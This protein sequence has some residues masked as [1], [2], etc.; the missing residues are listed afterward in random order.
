LAIAISNAWA[1][2]HTSLTVS[3]SPGDA[4]GEVAGV[5]EHGHADPQPG[6]DRHV[7]D[8]LHAAGPQRS[9]PWWR[10][11]PYCPRRDLWPFLAGPKT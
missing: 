5:G 1:R 10:A 2:F 11:P 7:G 9:S 6:R 4:K 3:L 8:D